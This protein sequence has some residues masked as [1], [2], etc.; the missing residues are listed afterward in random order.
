MLDTAQKRAAMIEHLESALGLSEE[1]SEPVTGYLIERA[2]DEARSR[3]VP[4][5]DL[6]SPPPPK[7]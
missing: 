3:Q 1:L 4:G 2:L 7:R 5:L 6:P